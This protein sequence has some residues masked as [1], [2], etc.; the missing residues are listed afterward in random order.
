MDNLRAE[1][2]NFNT[3]ACEQSFAW[4]SRHKKIM[5]AMTSA[6][7]ITYCY[8]TGKR[9][10]SPQAIPNNYAFAAALVDIVTFVTS[11]TSYF[12]TI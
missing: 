4:L 3:M 8:T 11:V 9:V 10:V 1:N 7:Y 12:E 2:H 5:C 6:T